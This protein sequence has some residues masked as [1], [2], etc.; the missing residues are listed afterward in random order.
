MSMQQTDKLDRLKQIADQA[1]ARYQKALAREQAEQRKKE[2]RRK[3]ILGSFV[4]QETAKSF[5]NEMSEKDQKWMRENH[6]DWCPNW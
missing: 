2:T 5:F 3:I 4:N 6:P 1:K